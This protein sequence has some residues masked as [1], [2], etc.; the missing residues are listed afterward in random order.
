MLSQSLYVGGMM[1]KSPHIEIYPGTITTKNNTQTI[2]FTIHFNK[3][4]N[5]VC[6]EAKTKKKEKIKN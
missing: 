6:K 3:I 1:Y 5:K 2:F 4:M